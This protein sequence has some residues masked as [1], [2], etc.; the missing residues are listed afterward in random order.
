MAKTESIRLMIDD[1]I[2]NA[3]ANE[4]AWILSA[5]EGLNKHLKSLTFQVEDPYRVELDRFTVSVDASDVISLMKKAAQTDG[6]FVSY[7]QSAIDEDLPM[8]ACL[9]IEISAELEKLEKYTLYHAVNVLLHQIMLAMNIA[10][11]GSCQFLETWFEGAEAEHFEA[12]EFD[13]A[14]FTNGWLSAFDADW[15]SLKPLK[16]ADVWQW[17]E[18]QGTSETDTALRATNKV[19]F[20]LLELCQQR[21]MFEARDALLVAHMLE[22]L[23]SA[24]ESG[25]PSL[26]RDR[27]VSILGNPTPKADSFNEL[28]R[29][30]HAMIRGDLP[31]RRPAL[32]FH[33]ADEEI[34][35]QLEAHNS[36]IE[37]ALAVLLGLLQDLV[38]NKANGYQFT[39]QFNRT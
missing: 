33:D 24:E 25:Q 12:P 1:V 39:E 11:P 6:G 31:V 26:V 17:L 13:S 14:M 32:T 20:G 35:Q 9:T 19:L 37:Q 28:Y 2:P 38:L 18:K 5:W 22:I 15:P 8:G 10:L 21:H 7:L 36:P 3:G 30:K 34:L 29:L 16:F 23:V 4:S 27:I